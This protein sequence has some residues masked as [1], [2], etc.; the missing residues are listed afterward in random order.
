MVEYSKQELIWKQV[1]HRPIVR[2]PVTLAYRAQLKV[3]AVQQILVSQRAH[4]ELRSSLVSLEDL[5]QYTWGQGK[6]CG[7]HAP[8]L[9]GGE[10][11]DGVSRLARRSKCGG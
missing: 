5:E 2:A 8:M 3:S 11:T 9:E 10:E 6:G 4:L 1:N 7:E